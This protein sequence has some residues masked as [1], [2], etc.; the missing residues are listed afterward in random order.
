[1]DA[2]HKVLRRIHTD[3]HAPASIALKSLVESLDQGMTFDISRL[4]SLGYA[5]FSLALELMKHWRLDSFRYERGWAT[6]V[7]SDRGAFSSG[8]SWAALGAEAARYS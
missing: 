1:M 7:A 6:R 3:P 2:L 8:P 5:D 4:Y